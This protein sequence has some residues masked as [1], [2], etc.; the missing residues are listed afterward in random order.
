MRELLTRNAQVD[1]KNIHGQTPFDVTKDKLIKKLL[2]P[3]GFSTR[4]QVSR[5][6]IIDMYDAS[7]L[8]HP[9]TLKKN[10]HNKGITILNRH[11][12]WGRTPLRKH[13]LKENITFHFL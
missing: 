12:A 9:E 8:N 7:E 1:V 5:P 3:H 10:I 2:D 6:E 4:T 13:I 11:G